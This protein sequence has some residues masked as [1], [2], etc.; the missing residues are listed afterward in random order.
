VGA[1]DGVLM[2]LKKAIVLPR[3]TQSLTIWEM[4]LKK[5]KQ[6]LKNSKKLSKNDQNI[7]ND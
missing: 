6:S 2:S 3:H 4:E 7:N 5:L 1:G